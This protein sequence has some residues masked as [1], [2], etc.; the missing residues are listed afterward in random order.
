[1]ETEKILRIFLIALCAALG[2]AA[3]WFTLRFLLVWLLPFLLAFLTAALLDPAILWLT[4]WMHVKRSYAAA[5]CVVAFIAVLAAL[6]ALFVSRAIY[7]LTSLTQQLPEL[8]GGIPNLLRMLESKVDGL[9]STA[10]DETRA[11]LDHALEGFSMK[12]AELPAELSE[13]LLSGLSAA[14]SAAPRTFLFTATYAISVF[15][16][17]ADFPTVKAFCI[18]QL[19]TRM[20]SGARQLKSDIFAG[21]GKWLKAETLLMCI[22]FGELSFAFLMM[23]IDYA[24]IL[25]LVIAIIDALP[26]FGTG[27]V[28]IP[29][30]LIAFISGQPVRAVTLLAVYGV[31][32]L[33][34][35]FLE[36]KLVGKQLG[37]HPLVTLMAMYVGFSCIGIAGMLLFPLALL[38]LKQLDGHGG[39]HLFKHEQ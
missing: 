17:C 27:T 36:P 10:S 6:A 23:R 3:A 20:H 7:E 39:F 1:M 19:P 24:F 31:V 30:A 35:S 28:L 32:S 38:V 14:A 11:Y 25:A 9:F 8:I 33:V 13:R 18:R 5:V 12:A 15:F 26:V 22:T 37:L 34:R 4:K 2:I 16:M 29:W 21:L